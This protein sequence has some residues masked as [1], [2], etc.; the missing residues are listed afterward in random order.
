MALKTVTKLLLSKQAPLSVEMQQ[1]VLA[2]QSVVKNI[3]TAEFSYPDNVQD[4][5]FTEM[6]VSNE[7]FEQCKQNIIN[8]ETTLQE[9]CDNGFEFSQAQ[10][11]ELEQLENAESVQA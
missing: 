2:D 10:Y 11:E 3:E 1:A 8:K 5:E 7:T 9:L 6:N 4:V